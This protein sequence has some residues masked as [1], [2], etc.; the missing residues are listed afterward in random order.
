MAYG[1][2]L[3]DVCRQSRRFVTARCAAASERPYNQLRIL[4]AVADDG[5][6]SQAA[7]AERLC[8]DAPAV[9][10]LV[11]RLA[12]DGLVRRREGDD[13]RCVRLAVTAEANAALDV[14]HRAQAELDATVAAGLSASERAELLR[15]LRK[16]DAALRSSPG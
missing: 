4:Q 10:R 6:E 7:L 14:L 15:L 8:L 9:S 2:L 16:I 5:V 1:K 11:D 3:I 13:R 12:K